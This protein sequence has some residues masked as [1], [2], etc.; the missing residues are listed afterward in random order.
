VSRQGRFGDNPWPEPYYIDFLNYLLWTPWNEQR[1]RTRLETQIEYMDVLSGLGMLD[2][3]PEDYCF[4]SGYCEE[5][6]TV[7]P[8]VSEI[9]KVWGILG[10]SNLL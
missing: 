3:I 1:G 5:D 7:L 9:E 8:I 4:I 2:I 6:G 10:P